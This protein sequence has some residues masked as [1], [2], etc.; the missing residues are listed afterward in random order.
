MNHVHQEQGKRVVQEKE[1]SLGA[2]VGK[3]R[4]SSWNGP[5]SYC[6]H[7]EKRQ[8]INM[9]ELQKYINILSKILDF[10]LNKGINP[11]INGECSQVRGDHEKSP[12]DEHHYL[13]GSGGSSGKESTC[14]CRRRKGHGFNPWVGKIPW[15]NGIPLQ[16]SCLENS[17]DR[18][19]WWA[20]VLGVTKSRTWLSMHAETFF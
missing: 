17:M 11:G 18:G 10:V 9:A 7:R 20:A 3:C 5:F 15:R 1:L 19:A 4:P 6:M 8:M 2:L 12:P 13:Y 14:Q 16:Y